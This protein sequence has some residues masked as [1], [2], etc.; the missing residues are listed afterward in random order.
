MVDEK[1]KSEVEQYQGGA[2]EEDVKIGGRDSFGGHRGLMDLSDRAVLV[3][4]RGGN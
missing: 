2:V 3:D 1:G 4:T